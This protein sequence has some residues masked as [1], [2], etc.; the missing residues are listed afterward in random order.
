MSRVQKFQP[1]VSYK[2]IT[3][4]TDLDD[5]D[6][7]DAG[8]LTNLIELDEEFKTVRIRYLQRELD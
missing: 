3:E 1:V 5:I 8:L 6:P 4:G 2:V 7:P